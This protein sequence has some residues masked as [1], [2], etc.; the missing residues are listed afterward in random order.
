MGLQKTTIRRTLMKNV[1]LYVWAILG[2]LSLP[3]MNAQISSDVKIGTQVWMTKNLDVSTYRNGDTIRY[4][5]TPS[6]WQ[7]AAIK[8]EGAWCYYNN[9]LK[10]AEIYG[11]L[12]NWYA[13]NDPRVL[14]PLGYHIPSKAE[15]SVLTNC[16]NGKSYNAGLKMK[17][18]E[19]WID[20]GNGSNSSGFNGL[21]GG[22]CDYIGGFNGV[23]EWGWWWS[24]SKGYTSDATCLNMTYGYSGVNWATSYVGRGFSVRCIKD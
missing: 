5:S 18:T 17:S 16:L 8:Q 12:Y 13:V 19:G 14:A 6:E 23:G 9:D 2:I 10:N 11:K 4:T 7:D 1:L 15:W 3:I 22:Y 24:S 20:G 21:P